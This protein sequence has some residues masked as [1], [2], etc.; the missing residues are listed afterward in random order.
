[1]RKTKISSPLDRVTKLC[2][3]PTLIPLLNKHV[4]FRKF[5]NKAQQISVKAF[6][7]VHAIQTILFAPMDW[8]SK[9]VY[10]RDNEKYIRRFPTPADFG[11]GTGT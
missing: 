6:V 2:P 1:M 10:S 9:R 7:L 8:D 3:R 11:G 5:S 4:D